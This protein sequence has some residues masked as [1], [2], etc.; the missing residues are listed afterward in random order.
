MLLGLGRQ[1]LPG[2]PPSCAFIAG[3]VPGVVPRRCH[4]SAHVWLTSSTRCCCL[5]VD[6]LCRPLSDVVDAMQLD[7]GLVIQNLKQARRGEAWFDV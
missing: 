1:L 2:V 4:A 6:A 7:T 3:A 5:Q